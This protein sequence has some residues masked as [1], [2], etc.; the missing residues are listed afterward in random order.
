MII[1]PESLSSEVVTS[2][3]VHCKKLILLY[4]NTT[5]MIWKFIGTDTTWLEYNYYY[6]LP[7]VNDSVNES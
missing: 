1:M 2:A 6:S 7:Q 3:A 5:Y 4:H